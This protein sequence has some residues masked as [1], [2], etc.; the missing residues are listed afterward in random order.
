MKMCLSCGQPWREDCPHGPK[1]N[2]APNACQVA[3]HPDVFGDVR[4]FHEKFSLPVTPASGPPRLLP[5]DEQEYR[6][7]FLDEESQEFKDA[8]AAGDLPAAV[9][10]L[11]D[12]IV[13]A[14]GTL[15]FM[16]APFDEG[17]REVCRANMDKVKGD[18][19]KART[20]GLG[21]VGARFEIAKPPGWRPPDHA[22][23]LREH[24]YV[25]HTKDFE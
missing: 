13:V 10:A 12:L 11:H 21:D 15:H 20:A 5:A 2:D 3:M 14:L 23:V 17:W 6:E 1:G 9:D 16:G 24:V 7:R 4:E 22:R 19:L 25:H 8:H 18:M